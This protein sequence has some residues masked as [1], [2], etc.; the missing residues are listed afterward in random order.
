MNRIG[1]TVSLSIGGSLLH[2][3]LGDIESLNGSRPSDS[4]V[5]REGSHVGE[6]V[7]HLLALAELVNRET[8]VLLVEEKS[9]FLTVYNVHHILN[10]IL[11]DEN[12]SIELRPDEPLVR[13]HALFLSDRGI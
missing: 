3:K 9:G 5:E 10:A 12:I 7:Q 4:G 1:K 13:L 11:C 6:A 2:R 8:V